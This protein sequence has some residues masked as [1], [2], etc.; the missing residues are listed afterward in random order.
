MI[1]IGNYVLRNL[2]TQEFVYAGVLSWHRG[3]ARGVIMTGTKTEARTFSYY[4]EVKDFV[5]KY[6]LDID[7]WEILEV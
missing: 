7:E 3:T 5:K 2:K 6:D 4:G 1:G